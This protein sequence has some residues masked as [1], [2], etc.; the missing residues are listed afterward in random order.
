MVK[1]KWKRQQTNER[2]KSPLNKTTFCRRCYSW[3]EYTHTHSHSHAKKR[4]AF[5][6]T[7]WFV[8]LSFLLLFELFMSSRSFV[9]WKVTWMVWSAFPLAHSVRR[10]LLEPFL[11]SPVALISRLHFWHAVSV[12]LFIVGIQLDRVI[13]VLIKWDGTGEQNT[14][15]QTK[16]H[17]AMFV[18]TNSP[19]KKD[20]VKGRN[21][22]KLACAF[23]KRWALS[24]WNKYVCECS[25]S[26]SF[27][28]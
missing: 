22:T 10:F 5:C 7:F 4:S 16:R 19:V 18:I 20:I 11:I 1:S 24:V 26:V 23:C 25:A 9:R 28:V 17:A 15:R 14:K 13:T 3:I 21:Y 12:C 8:L 27:R 2:M 6:V